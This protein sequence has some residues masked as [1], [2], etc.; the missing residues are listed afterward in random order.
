MRF[1]YHVLLS[2]TALLALGACNDS[3][4]ITEAGEPALELTAAA[5]AGDRL[6]TVEWEGSTPKLYLQN[7]DGSDRKQV[8]FLHVSDHVT[9]NY[10]PR[11]LPVTDE[12]IRAIPR[13]KWSPD[14]RFLAVVVA[15]S[16]EALQIVLVSA[17]G[18]ALRTVS[19]N[20]QYLWGDIEW[21][22]DGKWLAYIL[23][24]GPFGRAPDL[25]VTELGIDKVTRVTVGSK[26][27]GYDVLR[28][29]P[30]GHQLFI[31]ERLG[32]ADDGVN[33]LARLS[34]VDLATGTITAGATVIGE[35]QGLPRDGSW[36]LFM[37]WSASVP[38]ARELFRRAADGTETVLAV[39][40]LRQAVVLE[41]D[42]QAILVS[43]P[44][45]A[46]GDRYD[47]IGLAQPGDLQGN[48]PVGPSATWAAVWLQ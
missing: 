36:S 13:M 31:T 48:L 18:R 14:G 10:S 37:R 9:G 23:A 33:G 28:F 41:D 30:S 20:S 40:D 38:G 25:F 42:A 22:L 2:T 29:D 19:P 6:A 34:T 17:D 7:L 26:L 16:T 27:S 11:Q 1:R 4:T 3:D 45:K 39:G 24:T 35:P 15:P 46:E 43:A 8:H 5:P 47:L 44:P 12:S 21:S 32:F